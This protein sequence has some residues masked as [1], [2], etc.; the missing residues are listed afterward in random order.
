MY[1]RLEEGQERDGESSE[2]GTE[3]QRTW[4]Q[5]HRYEDRAE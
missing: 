1:N 4:N 5:A 3:A 2:E